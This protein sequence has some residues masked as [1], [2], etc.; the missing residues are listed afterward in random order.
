MRILY[1][2]NKSLV[3]LDLKYK[4]NALIFTTQY[5]FVALATF[6]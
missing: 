1:L 3:N 5:L 2:H 4:N 6:K